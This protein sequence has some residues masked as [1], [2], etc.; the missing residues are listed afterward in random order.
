M[1][2][3]VFTGEVS[4]VWHIFWQA[5]AGRDL[6]AD[7]ALISRVRSRV[8]DAHRQAGRELLYYLLTPT[9]IHLLTVLPRHES[10]GDLA[11]GV[12]NVVARW[13]REVQ[14]S[15]GPV[16]V[17]RYQAR[18]I[19][20]VDA[21]RSEIRMLAWRPVAMQ[22]C[23]AATHFRHAAL[24]IVLGLSRP[25]GFHAS[26]LLSHFGNTV[27]EARNSLRTSLSKRPTK[28]EVLQWELAH[29]L[30]LAAGS[31]GPIGRMSRQVRGG[32]AALVAACG[33]KGIDGALQ[34]L[35]RWVEAKLGIRS[36]QSLAHQKGLLG[37]RGRALVAILAVRSGLCSA[38]SVARHFKRAKATLSEQ[39]AAARRRPEDKQILGT[40]IGR[41]VAEAL[42]LAANERNSS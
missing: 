29:G 32:A 37:A 4:A 6:L 13:V 1:D 36:G 33:V 15:P 22:L 14:G 40:S 17:S 39:M 2:G 41:V 38:A 34:L 11:R 25:E 9:E 18:R 31:V 30:A 24:R 5:A 7:P 27:L 3:S 35:E 42:A 16:F 23:V 8:L 26:A 19:E 12:A 28:V 20:S 10:A 21:L